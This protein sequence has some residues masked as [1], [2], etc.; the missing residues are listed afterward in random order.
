M[1]ISEENIRKYKPRIQSEKIAEIR[2]Y[3][4]KE[5]NKNELI[6]KKH[7]KICRVLT[8]I[9]QLLIRISTITG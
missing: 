1:I 6:K 5:I 3:L 9:D 8:Y 4:F 2:S 7:K